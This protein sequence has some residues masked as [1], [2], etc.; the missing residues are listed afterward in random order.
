[1][2]KNKHF[3]PDGKE[4]LKLTEWELGNLHLP[5]VTTVTLY[6]GAAPAEFLRRRLALMLEK[7]PWL[8]ARIVKKNTAD[9]VVAL[10]YAP[11]FELEQTID[12]HFS[13]YEPGDVGFSLSM[14]YEELVECLVPV[15]CA[16]S[17][18]ATDED[19][20]LFKVAVVPIEPAETADNQPTPLQQSLTLPGFALVVSMNHTLGDGHTYYTLYNMLSADT[21]V[22]ALIPVRVDNFEE[23]KTEVVGQEEN[24]MFTSA[25]LGLGIVGT[26]VGG[27]VT[28]REPQNVCVHLVDP[29]W[30]A[31]E[32]AKAKE[33]GQ[34]PFIST[35]DALTSWFFREMNS[36]LNLMLANFRSREP[37]VLGLTDQ[38][39]GNYEANVPYF[40]GDVETPTL[41][42]QSIRSADGSFQARRAGS[43]PTKIPKFS[44]LIHNK[45]SIVTNW[46][47]F[48]RDVILQNEAS[49]GEASQG[50]ASQ[51]EGQ[52]NSLQSN[53]PKLHL[54]IMTSE[55]LILSVWHS[56]V[57]FC[58]RA[59][60]VGM[61]MITRHFDSDTL[62]QQKA[63]QGPNVPM[64]ARIV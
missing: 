58:P 50:E 32:K 39:V 13:V 52:D 18:P 25:G 46:A 26:Y 8:T 49:Q 14:A 51:G 60:Q 64:G 41:I 33:A 56:G 17:K 16:L 35:N 23:A 55:G 15:Q 30:I 59:G 2:S 20:P 11:T 9:G 47:S 6:Q 10:A 42:R 19:E 44:T 21:E 53:V 40:P 29:V 43:P 3:N 45:T 7:N 5:P 24:A 37:S 61:F 63:E 12:Q 22:E 57:I 54:P 38:H 28:R 48:Y 31:Q 4:F 34:V 36:D 27:K 1:M 62:A